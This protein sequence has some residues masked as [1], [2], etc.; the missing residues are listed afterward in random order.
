MDDEDLKDALREWHA[1]GVPADLEARIWAAKNASAKGPRLL[2][3]LTGSVRIPV[4]ALVLALIVVAALFYSARR[5]AP[6]AAKQTGLAGFQPVH[7]L[8]LRVVGRDY[9]AQ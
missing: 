5:P 4:P 2:W 6:Q 7:A 1:P 8:N 3:L 9:E